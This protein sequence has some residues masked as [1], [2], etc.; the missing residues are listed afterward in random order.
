MN[1]LPT[2]LFGHLIFSAPNNLGGLFAIMD[3]G[4]IL[5]L[6]D[7]GTCGI[8]WSPEGIFLR[9]IQQGDL[10]ALTDRNGTREYAGEWAD[11]HDVL[12]D[13]EDVYL[14]STQHNAVIRWNIKKAMEDE[15]WTFADPEDAWHIN[16]LGWLHGELC[17]TAFGEFPISRGY[18][19]TTL[20][21]GF[22]RRLHGNSRLS[23]V[24]GLS[25]PHSILG[26]DD[27]DEW[28]LCNSETGEVWHTAG[29]QYPCSRIALDG[30]T[31]GLAIRDGILY[32][33]LS[34]SRNVADGTLPGRAQIV[35]IDM[36]DWHEISRISLPSM[37]VYGIVALSDAETF[38]HLVARVLSGERIRAL[39]QQ[40]AI[41]EKL[42]ILVNEN[43]RMKI[44]LGLT[45][46]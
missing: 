21:Q 42:A 14:V 39:N 44:A 23:L 37:E 4:Q 17:F 13:G 5:P 25:Q 11:L 41:S 20:N 9:G 2:S 7:R 6:D 30:Y 32:V 28:I 24:A 40:N 10:L 36:A 38:L 22:L 3:D 43:A 35:A 15:R 19:L 18:K 1:D 16:C 26:I 33:G 29:R 8:H 46:S 45:G 31:R 34:A 12:L 27:V